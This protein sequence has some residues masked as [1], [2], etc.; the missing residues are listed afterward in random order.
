MNGL[1][2][3]RLAGTTTEY[4]WTEQSHRKTAE[5]PRPSSVDAVT[6]K[7]SEK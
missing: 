2:T 6:A 5:E 3:F 7:D 4:R 1:K